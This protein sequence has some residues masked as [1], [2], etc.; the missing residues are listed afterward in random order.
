MVQ[1]FEA[2]GFNVASMGRD[3]LDLTSEASIY[4]AVDAVQ[5]DFVVNAAR[6]SDVDTAEIEGDA[7][8]SL[9][10]E[11]PVNLALACR[12]VGATLIS[13]ST[14]YVFDGNGAPY[15]E[16]APT[17]PLNLFGHYSREAELEISSLLPQHI[18]LRVGF[19]FSAS[20]N[21]FVAKTLEDLRAHRQKRMVSDEIGTPTRADDLA[22]VVTA[23]I[24]QLDLGSE[25]FGIY[26][27][28]GGGSASWFEMGEL[29]YAQALQ[30]EDLPDHLLQP[31]RGSEVPG[32]APRPSDVRLD[33]D[34]LLQNFG[35][36]RLPWRSQMIQC[37]DHLY[38]PA[39]ENNAKKNDS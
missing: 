23:Q 4:S 26:H 12:Q 9:L 3:A 15:A 30:R 24:R 18:I 17:S 14:E 1:A 7:A 19:I 27:Y 5:P 29:I 39:A 25:A 8:R 36:K 37:V 22:R 38:K 10:Q 28:G 31:V 32:R 34:L 11:G 21:R 35:I 2:A 20:L 16:S 6:F 13:F 33:C